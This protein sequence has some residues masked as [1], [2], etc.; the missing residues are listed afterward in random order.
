[1]FV[2]TCHVCTIRRWEFKSK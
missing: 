2:L 1:M